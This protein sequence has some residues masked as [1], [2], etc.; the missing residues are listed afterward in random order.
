MSDFQSQT[1]DLIL[2]TSGNTIKKMK[3]MNFK[4]N[5]FFSLIKAAMSQDMNLFKVKQKSESKASKI[6]FPIFLAI[7]LMFCIGGYA[8]SIAELLTPMGLID[9]LL[10]VFI[11][12]TAILTIFEGAYKSQGILFESKD[13]D[14]LFSLPI[15]KK[16]IFFIRVLKL[17]V[18][19]LLY[20]SLFLIPSVV[21]YGIYEKVNLNFCIFSFLM[22]VLSPIIPTIIGCF[23]GYIIKGISSK[24]KA[25]KSAQV[26]LSSTLL[27]FVLYI[28][29]NK[30]KIFEY[31]AQNAGNIDVLVKKIYYPAVLFSSLIKSFNVIDFCILIAINII[32]VILFIYLGSIFYFKISSK[33]TEKGISRKNAIKNNKYNVKTPLKALIYKELKRFFTSP[34]FIINSA[35][36]LLLMVVATIGLVVNLEGLVEAFSNG[37]E[38]EIPIDTVVQIIPKIYFC[39]VVLLSFTTS[40]TS[41]MISLEG[42]NIDITKSLPVS[43]KKILLAKILTSNII[44]V[45]VILVC[46]IIFFA[47]FKI[48]ILDM[49]LITLASIIFP[50]FSAILGLIINLKHPKLDANS[51]AEVIKQSMS[52]FIAVFA[53]MLLGLT[54]SGISLIDGKNNT[55]ML[56]EILLYGMLD[57]LLWLYIAKIGTKK[58]EK[59]NV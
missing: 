1:S 8:Y 52:S 55:I 16:R 4:M 20:N 6:I 22:I 54:T 2:L 36:G 9:V 50:T 41:S 14:L 44:S 11:I 58:F 39:L 21:V 51:D 7:V 56:I 31:I 49:L 29:L 38:S 3:G 35:F 23:I 37:M 57:I 34:V 40:I 46:D 48:K 47:S 17:M 42:K 5:Q 18:F 25:K 32:P 13:S 43:S 27:L 53:G 12:L 19:Q 33:S 26:I 28:S 45:P 59:L 10:S 15:T 30:E 24:F